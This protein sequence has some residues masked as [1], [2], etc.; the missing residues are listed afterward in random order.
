MKP[1]KL[2]VLFGS[3]DSLSPAL[4][5]MIGSSNAASKALKNTR[6]ELKRLNDQQR[7]LDSFKS[8]KRMLN[9]PL[10]N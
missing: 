10:L 7:Q 4:K 6:D 2:E 9:K 8:L 1:L 5:L 3:K